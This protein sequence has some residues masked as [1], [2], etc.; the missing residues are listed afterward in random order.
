DHARG[1]DGAGG[2]AGDRVISGPGFAA[3]EGALRLLEPAEWRRHT[4]GGLLFD[5]RK[6]ETAQRPTIVEAPSRP[7]TQPASKPSI[8]RER[9]EPPVSSAALAGL[10]PDQ[11]A[12]ASALHGPLLIVAGP[13]S[14]KTRM[15][16]HR[17][18]HLVAENGVAPETCLAITFTR[19]AAA[20]MKTRLTTLLPGRGEQVAVHT[21]HSLGLAI[22]RGHAS[23]RGLPTAIYLADAAYRVTRIGDESGLTVLWS[24]Q[25]YVPE[26]KARGVLQAIPRPKRAQQPVAADI[27]DAE[28]AYRQAMATRN[29][30]DFD[31]LVGLTLQM[32]GTEVG[33]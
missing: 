6:P 14:G 21:F 9:I 28:R 27:A 2:R 12:A 1:G 13:G 8:T 20:E 10:D 5:L 29:W 11:R 7:P 16:T 25:R 31:D 22:L 19:R 30:I 17:I 4:A 23:R 24:C 18:A 33:L 3:D 32:L 15:L 26:H